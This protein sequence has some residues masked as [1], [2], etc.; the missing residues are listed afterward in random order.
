MNSKED[1]Y[2]EGNYRFRKTKDFGLNVTYITSL[3]Y[4]SQIS[5]HQYPDQIDTLYISSL[6]VKDEFQRQG[7]GKRI[8]DLAISEAKRQGGIKV[9]LQVRTGTWV[10]DWYS[11]Y[12]FEYFCTDKNFKDTIWM[13]KQL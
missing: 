6:R 12:G 4:N 10:N 11:R 1:I 9:L 3:D 5:L 2:E 7:L 13:I 8:L